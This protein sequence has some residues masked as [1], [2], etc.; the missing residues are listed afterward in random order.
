MTPTLRWIE[1]YLGRRVAL[2]TLCAI[3]ALLIVSCVLLLNN[4]A[5]SP[6]LYLDVR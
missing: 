4:L 3:Y 1:R 2:A 5:K 6:M